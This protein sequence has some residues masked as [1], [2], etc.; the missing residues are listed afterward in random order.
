[1]LYVVAIFLALATLAILFPRVTHALLY[2]VLASSI[3]AAVLLMG[4]GIPSYF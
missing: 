2:V 1:M 4:A 3:G